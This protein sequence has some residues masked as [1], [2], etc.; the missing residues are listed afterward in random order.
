MGSVLSHKTGDK[1]LASYSGREHSTQGRGDTPLKARSLCSFDNLRG[2]WEESSRGREQNIF[3]I[4]L[5]SGGK[6]L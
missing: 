2:S 6:A 3:N 5:S 4:N 1:G